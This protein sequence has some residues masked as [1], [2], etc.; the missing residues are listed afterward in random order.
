MTTALSP[1]RRGVSLFDSFRREMEDL[2]DRFVGDDG[3][4][5]QAVSWAPRVDVEETDKEFLVKADIPG[6]DPKDVDIQVVDNVL[7]IRGGKE[8]EKKEEKKKNYHRIERFSGHFFRAISLPA[9]ADAD[10]VNATSANGVV[11]VTIPK[12]L[13]AQPKKIAVQPKG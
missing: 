12:K 13:E 6:V 9:G 1:Y 4:N 7:T 5:G 3:T 8:E 2:F 10:K 11:T